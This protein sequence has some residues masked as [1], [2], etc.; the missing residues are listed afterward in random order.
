LHTNS[1][2]HVWAF[3]A[4]AELLGTSSVAHVHAWLLI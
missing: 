4:I 2:S 3:G 1:T